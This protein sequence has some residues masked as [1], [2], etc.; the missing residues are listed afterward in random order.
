MLITLSQQTWI[1]NVIASEWNFIYVYYIGHVVLI[2]T[3][4]HIIKLNY[5]KI[6]YAVSVHYCTSCL[7]IWKCYNRLWVFRAR[8][9][10]RLFCYIYQEVKSFK[11][12]W[13]FLMKH[14][15]R[16][17]LL[18]KDFTFCF[19]ISTGVWWAFSFLFLSRI[20][21]FSWP[22]EGSMGSSEK[23]LSNKNFVTSLSPKTFWNRENMWYVMEN[24]KAR[25]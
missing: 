10:I 8:T 9:Y 13:I 4:W 19:S 1:A 20:F 17:L 16:C 3:L 11:H 18:W 15:S 22:G 6:C 23:S 7:L 21:L 25:A 14:N 2:I 24:P 12:K 5:T